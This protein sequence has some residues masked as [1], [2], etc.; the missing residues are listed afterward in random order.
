LI[1]QLFT[2]PSA[3]VQSGPYLLPMLTNVSEVWRDRQRSE[4]GA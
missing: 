1:H 2:F 4:R 3:T